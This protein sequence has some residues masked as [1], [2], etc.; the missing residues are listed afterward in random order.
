M[1]VRSRVIRTDLDRS[2]YLPGVSARQYRRQLVQDLIARH[3]DAAGA[4]REISRD[5]RALA[6][7]ALR[8]HVRLHEVRH[9]MTFLMVPEGPGLL[10]TVEDVS[11]NAIA[12]LKGWE[13]LDLH[14]RGMNF[15]REPLPFA[16]EGVDGML[17]CEVIEHYNQDP[18]FSLIEINRVLRPGGFVVVSTPNAASWFQIRRALQYLQPNR[19]AVYSTNGGQNHIHAREYVPQ[20]LRALLTVAGF[21]VEAM[22][23]MD[24]GAYP[25]LA[26][27]PGAGKEDR[28]ETIF[29]RARKCGPPTHRYL[30]PIY[31][32]TQPFGQVRRKARP[33]RPPTSRKR[34]QPV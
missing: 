31:T 23:T 27:V 9:L 33:R 26:P 16:D 11:A 17:V 4:Y 32:A 29:C 14:E 8:A 20:E 24:Y 15:E 22:T 12:R 21:E 13:I 1:S 18:L 6:D 7:P 28:G 5:I 34:K 3:R 25:P 30:A 19:Y 10:L 2:A